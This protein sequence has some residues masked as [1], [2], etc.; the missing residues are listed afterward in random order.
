[1][2]ADSIWPRHLGRTAQ[3]VVAEPERS[4]PGARKIAQVVQRIVGARVCAFVRG[5]VARPV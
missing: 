5:G 4:R 2:R 1:M 3:R